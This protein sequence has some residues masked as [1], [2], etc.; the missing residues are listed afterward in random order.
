MIN[1]SVIIPSYNNLNT[2][3]Q[4]LDSVFNQKTSAIYEVIVVDSSD[5]VDYSELPQKYP[6]L[7]LIK[8]DQ[9]TYPGTARNIG[10]KSA[11]GNLIAFTDSDCVVTPDWI[12]SMVD[13]HKN[14]GKVLIGGAVVNGT[15]KNLIGIAEYIL[16]FS[17]FLPQKNERLVRTLPTCNF[18]IEKKLLLQIGELKD[19]IKGSDALFSNQVFEKGIDIY[20]VPSIQISHLNRCKLKK[21][22]KNQRDLG[23]GSY[24][25]RKMSTLPGSF[26]VKS[27]WFVP[28][29]IPIRTLTTF[30]KVFRTKPKY[31]FQLILVFP[32]ILLGLFFYSAGFWQA[33]NSKVN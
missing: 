7:N 31:V 15:P 6:K 10:V 9:R 16:E 23:F 21:Y 11:K 14:R 27:R 1:I 26:L 8:L 28:L 19:V 33:F 32:L 25:V 5:K 30:K 24:R 18:S 13:V 22:L 4:C 20:F 17:D 2:I 29:I 3:H 12:E